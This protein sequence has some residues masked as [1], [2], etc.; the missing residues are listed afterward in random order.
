[1]LVVQSAN[2]LLAAAVLNINKMIEE[3]EKLQAEGGLGG[4]S[5]SDVRSFCII[6]CYLSLFSLISSLFSLLCLL[7]F[8]LQ[9]L[10]FLQE[11]PEEL[12]AQFA[13]TIQAVNA[14]MAKLL[15]PLSRSFVNG[16]PLSAEEISE[17]H[18]LYAPQVDKSPTCFSAHN[19]T[20]PLFST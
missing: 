4:G 18:K 1:M 5:Q 16:T 19:S 12:R 9:Q 15:E 13:S 10:I 8:I 2:S 11:I 14:T 20:F 6:S 17:A 3:A 7:F